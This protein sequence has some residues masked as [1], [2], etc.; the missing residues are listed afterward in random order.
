M[1]VFDSIVIATV[2]L[3]KGM[4]SV[5]ESSYQVYFFQFLYPCMNIAWTASIFLTVLMSFE[6]FLGICHQNAA[7]TFCTHKK[8]MIYIFAIFFFSCVYNI[9]RFNEYEL[10][11]ILVRTEYDPELKEYT[12][13]KF[14]RDDVTWRQKAF[15]NVTVVKDLLSNNIYVTVYLTWFNFLVRFLVPTILL[16][17]FNMKIVLEVIFDSHLNSTWQ[18]WP[19][20]LNWL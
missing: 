6:R 14:P 20:I 1:A 9:P 7:K 17:F 2:L 4:P 15:S 16:I 3:L 5:V 19:L 13:N 18:L 12:W 11:D 10:V 8:T